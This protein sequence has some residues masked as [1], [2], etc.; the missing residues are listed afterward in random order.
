MSERDKCKKCGSSIKYNK[1]N[2]EYYC[3]N[4]FCEYSEEAEEIRWREQEARN[5]DIGLCHECANSEGPYLSDDCSAYK[6]PLFMVRRKKKCKRF[7]PIDWSK[8]Q[9]VAYDY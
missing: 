4:K 1:Y 2:D 5:M 8:L 9:E 6:M 7:T 3:T